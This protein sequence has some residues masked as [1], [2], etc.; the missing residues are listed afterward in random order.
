MLMIDR[1]LA[2]MVCWWISPT[3]RMADDVWRSLKTSLAGA[4]LDKNEDMRRIDLPGGGLIRVQSGHDPDALRGA[5]LDLAVLDEAAFLDPDVWHAA[6]R[7]A[8]ADRRGEAL[9]LSTPNGRNWFWG[10]YMLG[11]NAANTQW[12]SWRF[13][14]SANPL[15]DPAEIDAAR[16]TLP[17]R[18]FKQEYEA[19]FLAD[20]GTVFR[21]VEA[22]ATGHQQEWAIPGHRY[23]M[24]IDLARRVDYTVCI[25]L[26]VST[27]P[28]EMAHI[29][30]FN[31][32]DWAIQVDRIKALALRFQIEQILVDQTGVGDPVV[33]QLQRELS[34]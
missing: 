24:G 19:E 4:W 8:L 34:G 25:V 17:E 26:D 13:P 33:E 3:Y 22:V 18:L 1:A 32:V 31:Q 12:Q 7:P 11:Q 23:I 28:I 14:T 29:D 2:G 15:I 5:G 21:R 27:S 20:T 9:F 30:R 6:I 10:L 16:E